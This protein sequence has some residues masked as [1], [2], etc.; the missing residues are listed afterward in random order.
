MTMASLNASLLARKGTAQ[1]AG[2]SAHRHL[3]PV[4]TTNVAIKSPYT[5]EKKTQKKYFRLGNRADRD[6][7][8]LAVRE[9]LS[10]QALM[11]Q[12]ITEYLD[13]AFAKADCICRQR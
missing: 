2:N 8:L 11:E 9:G 7:K 1:P 10:Q 5:S 6:L 13:R 3:T 12:A 4:P